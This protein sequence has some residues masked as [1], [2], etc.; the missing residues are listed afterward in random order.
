ML[1]VQWWASLIHP[2]DE[3]GFK[4][5]LANNSIAS[6]EG[7]FAMLAAGMDINE[8]LGISHPSTYDRL[9]HLRTKAV[10]SGAEAAL[11][12]FMQDFRTEKYDI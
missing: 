9:E 2:S 7:F 5:L 6:A 3:A 11:E 12:D 10:K 1:Q 4:R 8:E